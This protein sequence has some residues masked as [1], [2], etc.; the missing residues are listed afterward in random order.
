MS[1]NDDDQEDSTTSTHPHYFRLLA[2]AT[3]LPGS[4]VPSRTATPTPGSGSRAR[5][6]GTSSDNENGSERLDEDVGVEGYYE[7]FFVEE[8]K[9]G[10][11]ARG[12]VYLCQVSLKVS[13]SR[14][15]LLFRSLSLIS[16]L[17]SCLSMS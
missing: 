1:S 11:G 16:I 12:T 3:S 8:K 10:R 5:R 13:I 17:S 2:E 9:L 4:Q 14:P 6:Q 7:R 15:I